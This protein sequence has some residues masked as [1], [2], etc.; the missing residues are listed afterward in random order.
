M[1]LLAAMALSAATPV[2]AE[3]RIFDRRVRGLSETPTEY[4]AAGVERRRGAWVRVWIRYAFERSGRP[5]I[6]TRARIEIDCARRRSRTLET[7][8][9]PVP[10]MLESDEGLYTLHGPRP[11]RRRFHGR[12]A[13]IAAG[14][15][16]E[17]LARRLCTGR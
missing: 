3:W 8:E 12:L 7:V 16:D 14:S 17:A 11:Q 4:D 2:E 5:D 10:Y 9:G 13:P 15:V 6:R 1:L